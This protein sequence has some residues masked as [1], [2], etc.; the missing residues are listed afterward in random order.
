MSLK[1]TKSIAAFLWIATTSL[2]ACALLNQ[3]AANTY[4]PAELAL[5]KS[6]FERKCNKC[7]EPYL[8][9]SRS[10]K[11]WNQILPDMTRRAKL[12][13]KESEMVKA[14]LIANARRP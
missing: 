9:N 14:W 11:A 7:H 10:V 4:T 3:N 8:P 1:Y 5:G 13:D 6:T 12:N 2:H